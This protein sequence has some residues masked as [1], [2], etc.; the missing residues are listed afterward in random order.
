MK[1]FKTKTKKIYKIIISTA[2]N[3]LYGQ[4]RVKKRHV[5]LEKCD[6]F[7]LTLEITIYLAFQ[8]QQSVRINK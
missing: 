1:S 5:F 3:Y 6:A 4:F 2:H 7:A 8:Q